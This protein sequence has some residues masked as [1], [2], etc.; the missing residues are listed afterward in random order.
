VYNLCVLDFSF[1]SNINATV[2]GCCCWGQ[3]VSV[4]VLIF[5][6]RGLVDGSITVD[7]GTGCA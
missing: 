3:T 1:L 2:R 6:G 7:L 5:I 4:L